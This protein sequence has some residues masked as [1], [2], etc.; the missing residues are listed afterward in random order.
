MILENRIFDGEPRPMYHTVKQ[1][2]R[3]TISVR[4]IC[5]RRSMITSS[6]PAFGTCFQKTERYLNSTRREAKDIR[7]KEK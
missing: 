5:L 6:E 7:T 2:L 4:D 1:F 3:L